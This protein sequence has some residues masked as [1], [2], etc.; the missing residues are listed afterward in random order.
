M[1]MT[2][3]RAVFLDKNYLDKVW[4]RFEKDIMTKAGRSR[5]I[6]PVILDPEAHGKTV[7]IPSTIGM[8]DLS[9]EWHSIEAGAAI[10]GNLGTV[11]RTKLID[12]VI[13]KVSSSFPDV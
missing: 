13:E 1:L 12:P 5:H 4:T 9:A 3:D 2:S 10:D 8:V 11:I 7:G 6:I